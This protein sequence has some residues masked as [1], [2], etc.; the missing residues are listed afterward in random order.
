MLQYGISL[1]KALKSL[2]FLEHLTLDLN[3]LSLL[4]LYLL[5]ELLDDLFFVYESFTH[6]LLLLDFLVFISVRNFIDKHSPFVLVA[7]LQ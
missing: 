1:M 7:S 3:Y 2:L 5:L 6:L 4:I